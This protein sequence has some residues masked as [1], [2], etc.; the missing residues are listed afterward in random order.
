M[1]SRSRSEDSKAIIWVVAYKLLDLPQVTATILSASDGLNVDLKQSFK[2]KVK[3][4]LKVKV[5]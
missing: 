5:V 2:L 1:L 4:I 3:V